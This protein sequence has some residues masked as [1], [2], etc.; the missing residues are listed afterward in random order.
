MTENNFRK[1]GYVYY[2]DCGF[3]SICI[4][5]SSS[6]YI[7]YT[8][9]VF[10]YITII[11]INHFFNSYES[12]NRKKFPPS[13]KRHHKRH[14]TN[15]FPNVG[16]LNTSPQDW[17]QGKDICSHHLHCTLCLRSQACFKARRTNKR[18]KVWEKEVKMSLFTRL[19]AY[20]IFKNLLN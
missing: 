18:H 10:L 16:I 20:N 6:N 3:T 5:L 1:W 13:E 19:N 9:A 12:R 8:C 14:A 17:E 15:V 7:H 2:F 11:Q 4:H